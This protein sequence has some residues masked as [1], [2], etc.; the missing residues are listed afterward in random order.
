MKPAEIERAVREALKGLE[1]ECTLKEIGSPSFE[2]EG[3]KIVRRSQRNIIRV[4]E[5]MGLRFEGQEDGDTLVFGFGNPFSTADDY[6]TTRLLFA[7][8]RN[9]GFRPA[10][11]FF[12]EVFLDYAE[13][14]K[15]RSSRRDIIWPPD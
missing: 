11:T 12:Q 5:L 8:D 1:W 3:G 6:M 9:Y 14:V 7:V 4:F 10:K 13:R 15:S 2:M